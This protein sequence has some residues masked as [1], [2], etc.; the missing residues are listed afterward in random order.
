M[1][2]PVKCFFKI[3]DDMVQS[4]LALKVL[5]IQE[6]E[7]EDLF[8]G[9]SPGPEPRLLFRNNTFRLRFEPVQDHPHHDFT[10]MTDETNGSDILAEL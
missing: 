5:F 10:W 9:A 6:S 1:T 3:F 7:V 8:C 2:Y 4:L